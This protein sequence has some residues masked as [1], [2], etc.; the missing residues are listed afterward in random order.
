MP[1]SH[2]LEFPEVP[3]PGEGVG[4][5]K[6]DKGVGWVNLKG[7]ML[8]P[9]RLTWTIIMKV[10]KIIFLS[11]LVICR[12]HVNLPG[13]ICRFC[14]FPSQIWLF[15][16]SS[17][18]REVIV[19]EIA[20]NLQFGPKF[21]G[22]SIS[23]CC[24]VY[25]CFDLLTCLRLE[26]S[27]FIKML[28]HVALWHWQWYDDQHI[29]MLRLKERNYHQNSTLPLADLIQYVLPVITL[30]V[31]SLDKVLPATPLNMNNI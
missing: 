24:F 8:H 30:F 14:W 15:I 3:I 10:W 22:V 28:T 1:E 21:L 11:K 7:G 26:D 23:P 18:F 27:C 20:T 31:L 16:H 25:P 13:C 12:F 2:F 9:G 17:N 6:I 29:N 19:V 5:E 4:K